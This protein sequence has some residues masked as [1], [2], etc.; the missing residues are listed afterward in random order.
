MQTKRAFLSYSHEDKEFAEKIARELMKSGIDLWADM[1]EIKA[2]DSLIQKIFKEGLAQCEVFLILISCSS[3]KSRWVH[4]EL[5][6]AMIKRIEGATRIIPL[7]KEKCEIPLTLRVLKW[8]DLSENFETGIKEVVKSIYDVSGKPPIGKVPEYVS[9]LKNSVGGLSRKA[10]TVGSIWLGSGDSLRGNERQ[11]NGEEL[12]TL[13]P[14]LSET[15]LN[16]AVDELK[17]YGLVKTIRFIGTAPYDFGF[18]EPTYALFLHFKDNGLDYDPLS[19]IK[20]IASALVATQNGK[21]NGMELQNITQLDPLRINRAAGY[22]EDYGL[23][24]VQAF[25]GTAPFNFGIIESTRKTRQFVDT[26][27]R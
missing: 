6:H 11:Y 4:E 15:E 21:L 22:L 7:I 8:V 18:V 23:I 1:W 12:H 14:M 25:L 5:D 2:G 24:N 3:V 20:A 16:D 27:C 26:N 17:E 10:S 13:V 19:D 9:E